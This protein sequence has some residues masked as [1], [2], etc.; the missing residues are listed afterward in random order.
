MKDKFILDA[1]CGSRMFWFNKK[2]PNTLYVDNRKETLKQSGKRGEINVNPDFIMDFRD[3][4]FKD[5][6]FK[7]IVLDPPH[8]VGKKNSC[9]MTKKY[10]YLNKD[11][12]KEDIKKGFDECWRVLDYYGVLVFKWSDGCVKVKDLLDILQRKP[13][14]GHPTIKKTKW[15]CFM[16]IPENKTPPENPK[17][18]YSQN[19]ESNKRSFS[20]L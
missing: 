3:L 9:D 12:W 13:L 16:K 8:L 6:S 17:T 14:F 15:F 5:N 2:H 11:T 10:G 7:L 20:K 19:Q 1:C 18:F 4:K